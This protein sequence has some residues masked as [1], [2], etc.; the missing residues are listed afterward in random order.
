MGE[1]E[2]WEM[3]DKL[4]ALN[5]ELEESKKAA[6]AELP[7]SCEI[8]RG[9]RR[10]WDDG[11]PCLDEEGLN[12][13][14]RMVSHSHISLGVVI[15]EFEITISS[16]FQ[17]SIIVSSSSAESHPFLFFFRIRIFWEAFS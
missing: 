5:K 10:I 16:I 2:M 1:D 14:F 11:Q 6:K 4:A 3:E 7:E 12:F 13:A 9:R 17:S 8:F 15:V